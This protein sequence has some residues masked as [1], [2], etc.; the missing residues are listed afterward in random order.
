MPKINRKPLN[1]KAKLPPDMSYRFGI[2]DR[3]QD[4]VSMRVSLISTEIHRIF[5]EN[6]AVEMIFHS[7]LKSSYLN[8]VAAFL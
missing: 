1:Q 5:Y 2:P 4:A 3:S 7:P 6:H 8:V